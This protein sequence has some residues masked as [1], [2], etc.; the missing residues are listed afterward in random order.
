MGLRKDGRWGTHAPLQ[1][2]PDRSVGPTRQNIL[3][4]V[5]VE[6]RK[7]VRGEA[8]VGFHAEGKFLMSLFLNSGIFMWEQGVAGRTIRCVGGKNFSY[9]SRILFYSPVIVT[10]VRREIG[11]W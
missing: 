9:D 10:G 7:K 4:K 8:A 11:G 6:S 5:Q 3:V 2:L 1:R